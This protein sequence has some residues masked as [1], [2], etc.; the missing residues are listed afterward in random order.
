MSELP[1]I[2]VAEDS[3][4]DFFF[5][6]RAL[7]LAQIENPVLRFRDG[8][9]VVQFVENLPPAE[10]AAVRPA[11]WLLLVDISMPVMNGFEL[12]EWCARRR[13]GPR[14]RP[15]VLSGSYRPEDMDRARRLG[16]A[17][18]LVKPITPT[19]AQAIVHAEPALSVRS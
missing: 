11:P 3:D 10:N 8:A 5:L 18:Y 13:S 16:A 2:L 14:L 1:P 12:L 4:D 9:E 7:R 17:D 6:R 15:V 19:I